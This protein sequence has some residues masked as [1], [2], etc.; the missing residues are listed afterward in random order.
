MDPSLPKSTHILLTQRGANWLA[1][2]DHDDRETAERLVDSLTLVSH[3][4]FERA[5]TDLIATHAAGVDGF[6]ALYA[7]R[8]IDPKKSYFDQAASDS[9]HKGGSHRL[10][11]VSSG[12]DLGSEAR[13][14]AMIRNIVKGEP[15]KF[16]NHPTV[17]KMR[18][19]RC[20]SVVI[21]DDL[22][23]S[24][25]RVCD[26]L[27]ALWQDRSIRSWRS[28]G[29]IQ[30][31]VISYS[32]TEKGMARVR[33]LKTHQ[34]QIVIARDCP[35]YHEMPWSKPL[36]TAA[37]RICRKYGSHTSRPGMALGYGDAM[38]ALVFE[39]GSPNN[40]PAIFWAPSTSK[41]PWTPLFPDRAVLSPEASAFP[42]EIARRDPVSVLL[43]VGQK[44]LARSGSLSRRGD[45]G[46]SVLVVL[47]L[48]AKGVRKASALGFATGLSSKDC[49]R[50]LERCVR[51]GFLTRTHRVTVTGLAELRYARGIISTTPIPQRGEDNYYPKK[52]RRATSG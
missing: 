14:A 48:V 25:K 23:G 9:T 15:N 37:V 7:A 12:S 36:R 29:Y 34:P 1:Q 38:T 11:A 27:S 13:I 32:A 40:V 19:V 24:G 44:H 20:R 22:I 6:V 41:K 33:R 39:H 42:P 16:L 49:A 43:D 8:E 10:D 28:L 50:I 17:E 18:S 35:T 47:G 5:L 52:L 26:F 45:V 46:A 3:S 21:V 30:F 51:W 4:A 2:F 31:A